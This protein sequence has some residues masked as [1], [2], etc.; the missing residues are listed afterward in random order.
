MCL[1]VLT[2]EA[3]GMRRKN[4]F[5]NTKAW[6]NTRKCYTQSVGG[7][8]ERCLKNGITQP[9][10]IV[11]HKIPLTDENVDDASI[12]LSWDNLQALC[13]KCHAE[14]HDEMYRARTGRRYVINADGKVEII[15]ER[16]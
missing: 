5:Y 6:Q 15:S 3:D 11:H 12:S 14:V 4:D 13:R 8:C 1:T 9:A 10:E 2:K 7:L 16:G